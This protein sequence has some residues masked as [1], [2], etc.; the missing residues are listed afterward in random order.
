MSLK[1][2]TGLIVFCFVAVIVA[3]LVLA[4]QLRE[5]LLRD[6]LSRTATAGSRALWSKIVES[7]VQRMRGR[8]SIVENDLRLVSALQSGD[9]GR[10]VSAA[11]DVLAALQA[12]RDVMRL[13]LVAPSREVLYSSVPAFEPAAAASEDALAD[14]KSVV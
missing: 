3:G 8:T 12:T 10:I 9:R 6:Q 2:R 11:R 14:R 4:G 7:G 13:D 5:G 1:A